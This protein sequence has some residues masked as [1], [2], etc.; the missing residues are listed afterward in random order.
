[1]LVTV[2]LSLPGTDVTDGSRGCSPV[3]GR[4]FREGR[5]Q[6]AKSVSEGGGWAVL[7]AVPSLHG[8]GMMAL[9]SD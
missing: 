1:M 9:M 5:G 4:S 3:R 2:L 6:V 7:L 8:P